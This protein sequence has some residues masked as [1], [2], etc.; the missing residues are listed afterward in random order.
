[1]ISGSNVREKLFSSP[2]IISEC[3]QHTASHGA[4][5]RLAH[6]SHR[7]THVPEEQNKTSSYYHHHNCLKAPCMRVICIP[8]NLC[9][10]YDGP[11]RLL[12][13][14][15]FT[16]RCIQVETIAQGHWMVPLTVSGK[17]YVHI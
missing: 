3:A 6:S 13:D 8:I 15:D 4:A 16:V 1:M 5:P 12:A 14:H 17:L 7:H 10:L 9:K 11:I 2:R